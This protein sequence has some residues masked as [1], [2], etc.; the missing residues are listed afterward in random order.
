MIVT[1]KKVKSILEMAILDGAQDGVME[2]LGE[3]WPI[4]ADGRA[5]EPGLRGDCL[6]TWTRF[7]F[8]APAIWTIP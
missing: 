8:I 4:A 3:Q 7:T 5:A 1:E 2:I 6:A